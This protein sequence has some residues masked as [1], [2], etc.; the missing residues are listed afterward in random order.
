MCSLVAICFPIQNSVV[1]PL[2]IPP[3]DLVNPEVNIYYNFLYLSVLLFENKDVIKPK[4]KSTNPLTVKIMLI[5]NLSFSLFT[6]VIVSWKIST[7]RHVPQNF[8]AM[9]VQ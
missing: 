2:A 7:I 1:A 3:N 5:R 6:T 9:F 4:Q 8:I